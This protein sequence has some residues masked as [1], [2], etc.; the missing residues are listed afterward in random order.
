MRKL[1]AFLIIFAMILNVSIVFAEPSSWALKEIERALDY[2]LVPD[3]LLSDYQ[4]DISREEFCEM[5]VKLYESL[6]MQAAKAVKENPFKDTKNPEILK[7][8]NLGIVYG[9]GAGKFAPENPISREEIAVMYYRTLKILNPSI[10]G[11]KISLKFEDKASISNWAEDAVAYMNNK[12]I[13]SGI[14][15]GKFGPKANASREQAIALTLRSYNSFNK[16]LRAKMEKKDGEE[17]KKVLSPVEI[18]Q[19]SD[20]VVMIEVLTSD[21]GYSIGSGFFYDKG[22]I[23]TNYHVIEDAEQIIIE[24]EDGSY[25][26]D[27][28]IISGYSKEN[29]LATLSI[30]DTKTKALSL[31]DSSKIK[32][33][34]D[35]YVIG[36][37]EGLKNSL[38]DGL[39][40]AVRIDSIQVNAAINPG[41]SG[42]ALL[43]QYG[44][45]VGIIYEKYYGS[46][47]LGFAIPVNLLKSLDKSLN[48]SVKA[49]YDKTSTKVPRPTNLKAVYNGL[50]GFH[51]SW[52]DMGADYYVV[53]AA[54]DGGDFYE[55]YDDVDGENI[56][57]WDYD[58]CINNYG[59]DPGDTVQYAV[60]S[61]IGENISEYS[62]SDLVTMP[63]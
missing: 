16:D 51:I 61:V 10:D 12:E 14:G 32:R 7:A 41:N 54:I 57:Y 15:K 43:N 20:S 24:Y 48:L 36:S 62:Y 44:E 5:I 17:K 40:S 6:S 49:F 39:I 52:D 50:D 42:G 33:G 27:K 46:E 11:S 22:K 60:A 53:Y 38:S 18:G 31:G 30:N 25:Y 9:V 45:V 58:Y 26:N 19:L 56:W 2:G 29:D 59:Y 35:I 47:N 28:V 63:K 21:G 37:P 8:Y 1:L 34:E 13:I 23:V 55:L 3:K 4:E